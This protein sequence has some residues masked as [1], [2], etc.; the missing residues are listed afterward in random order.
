MNPAL[1]GGMPEKAAGFGDIEKIDRVFM[2]NEV[3][4]IAQLFMQINNCLRW[5]RVVG[6]R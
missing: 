4:P 1:A 5:D 3:R 2:N 6:W